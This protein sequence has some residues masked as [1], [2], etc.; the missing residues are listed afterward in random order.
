MNAIHRSS[1]RHALEARLGLR[2][3]AGLTAGTERL[4]HDLTE[5]LR[6][7]RELALVRAREARSASPVA[8]VGVSASGGLLLGSF[9]PLL[10]RAASLLPLLLLLGGLLVIEQWSMRERVLAAAEIDMLLLA[11]ALP[12]SAYGDPGFAEFLRS[13]PQP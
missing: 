13:E 5:R 12:P 9:A 11:D 1:D 4:P 2:L 6:F 8:A 10:Q 3:A 7:A